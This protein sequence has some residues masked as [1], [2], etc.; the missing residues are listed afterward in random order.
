MFQQ[1]KA[2]FQIFSSSMTSQ[3]LICEVSVGL[4][5]FVRS[6]SPFC[7]STAVSQRGHDFH[8]FFVV[9]D[10]S[11]PDCSDLQ[12]VHTYIFLRALFCPSMVVRSACHNTEQ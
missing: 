3:I 8:I 6:L 2:S 11:Q 1:K 10:G 12:R 4:I 9:Q 7:L 5:H